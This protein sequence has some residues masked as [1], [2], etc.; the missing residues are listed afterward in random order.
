MIKIEFEKLYNIKLCY[1]TPN[2][3]YIFGDNTLKTGNGGQA[4]VRPMPNT[5]GIITKRYP[6]HE[7]QSYLLDTPHDAF[8]VCNSLNDFYNTFKAIEAGYTKFDTVVFPIDGLG[9]GLADM[10]KKCPELFENMKNSLRIFFK[11]QGITHI[12]EAYM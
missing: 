11:Q 12:P 3:L 1:Q 5:M 7:P 10:P 4:V 6:T 2:K 9:T 8:L